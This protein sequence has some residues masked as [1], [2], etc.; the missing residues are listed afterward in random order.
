ML[1]RHL[2]FFWS[3]SLYFEPV[4]SIKTEFHCCNVNSVCSRPLMY[5]CRSEI[6]NISFNPFVTLTLHLRFRG[7]NPSPC[8]RMC[9]TREHAMSLRVTRAP[10]SLPARCLQKKSERG[11]KKT[12]CGPNTTK[13]TLG[14]G[15][16]EIN[17]PRPFHLFLSIRFFLLLLIYVVR[18][19][20]APKL[21]P[22]LASTAAHLQQSCL[23]TFTID[24]AA[25]WDSVDE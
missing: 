13:Q 3:L 5:S 19:H 22:F 8:Q 7:R 23:N 6:G 21:N 15:A 18:E 12:N 16:R 24:G 14:W 20:A 11:E 4:N 1:R 10:V 9:C 2:D 25:K 17:L